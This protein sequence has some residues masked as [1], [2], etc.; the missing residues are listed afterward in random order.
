MQTFDESTGAYLKGGAFPLLLAIVSLAFV[1]I[2]LPLYGAILW[3]VII[4][5]VFAPVYRGLRARLG[6]RST[7]AALLTMLIVLVAV[8]LPFALLTAALANEAATVYQR[9]QSGDLNPVL[10]FRGVF[11]ALPGWITQVLDGFG[12]IDFDTLQ[13]RLVAALTTGTQLIATRALGIGQDTFEFVAGV[14]ITLYL[15][16]FLVRDGEALLR[17]VRRAIPLA[18]E[19]TQE[20]LSKFTTVLR[21]TVKG[22]L[23]VAAIQGALGGLAFW[24]LGVGGALLWA[25]LMAFLSLLPAIGAGLVWVPVAAYFL[26]TG[27]IWKGVALAA[28]GVLV[29]GLVDNLLRPVLVGKDTRMPDYLVMITTLGGMAVFG[30]NGFVLGPAIAA[31]F[32]TVWHIQG[33]AASGNVPTGRPNGE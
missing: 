11:D 10:Y 8:I 22:N 20:L 18:P 2:L 3:G 24:Y 14:F 17:D 27:A 1:W 25:V 33:A 30:L 19:H 6:G 32:I 12:L 7:L 13:R 21:A 28:Y 16:F 29:I 15:A 4:A 9:L 31:M 5:L 23:L 26:A